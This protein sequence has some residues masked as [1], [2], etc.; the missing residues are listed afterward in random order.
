LRARMQTNQRCQRE[1]L[2]E[3]KTKLLHS[4]QTLTK[5]KSNANGVNYY[6]ERTKERSSLGSPERKG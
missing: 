4:K 5:E 3:T 6:S 1:G 2:P